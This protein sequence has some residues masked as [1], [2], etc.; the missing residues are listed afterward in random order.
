MVTKLSDRGFYEWIVQRMSALLIGAYTVFLLVYLVKH[1][2]LRYAQWHALFLHPAM[3]I[4]TMI[5]LLSI[6]WHA[7]IGLWTV[8]TDYVKVVFVRIML[9][10]FTI[11]ALLAYVFWCFDALW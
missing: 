8:F 5:A 9:E 1:P 4:A 10:T 2:G 7:W 3:K 6:V 11:L